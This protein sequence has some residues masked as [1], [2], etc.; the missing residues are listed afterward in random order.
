[1]VVTVAA[2]GVNPV[3]TYI[4]SGGYGKRPLP[5]TPGS[6]AAGTVESVGDGVTGYRPGDRVYLAGTITGAYAEK[7]LCSASQVRPLP[8]RLSFAQG[9]GVHV[10]YYTALYGL[11]YRAKAR[12]GETVLVHGA[13]GGVGIAAVQLA[14]A[15]G[16]TVIGTAGSE[17]GR[18]LVA[19]QG[20]HH[21]F[22]HGKEGYLDEI[23]NVNDGKGVNIILE[24]LANINLAKDLSILAQKGRIVVIGSRGPIEIDP[25]QTMV[26]DS[27]ILGMSLANASESDLKQLHAALGAGLANGTLT[28]IISKEI[29]LAEALRAHHAIMEPGARGKIVLVP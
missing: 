12:P 18:T 19:K 7:T 5:Y 6:D 10:P 25:R 15:A 20:A 14:R 8:G 26:K 24:M 9:A 11:D 16:L 13:S 2:V 29:P 21:V 3:D 27:S 22:D 23:T 28:P 17:A 1:V 4:R